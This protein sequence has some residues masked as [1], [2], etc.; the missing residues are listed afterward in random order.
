MARSKND[1]PY[2][3]GTI[4]ITVHPYRKKYDA[5]VKVIDPLTNAPYTYQTLTDTLS[6]R[7]EQYPAMQAMVDA[8]IGV[9]AAKTAATPDGVYNRTIRAATKDAARQAAKKKIVPKLRDL[10]DILFCP[11]RAQSLKAGN[12]TLIQFVDYFGDAVLAGETP[13]ACKAMLASLRQ[14]ILPAIGTTLI[15]ALSDAKGQKKAVNKIN[16]ALRQVDAKD[17][18]RQYAK[19]ACQKLFQVVQSCGFDFAAD[20]KTMCELVDIRKQR[21]ADILAANRADHLDT[22][23]RSRVFDVLS[24]PDRLYDRWII[25]LLYSGLDYSEIAAHTFN[26]FR[27]FDLGHET[28]DY[29][30]VQRKMRKLRDRYSTVSATNKDFGISALRNVVLYPW[31]QQVMT[32]YIQYLTV[33]C[34]YTRSQVETMRLSDHVPGGQIIGN[35]ELRAIAKT[36]LDDAAIQRP[37][38]PRTSNGVT[39]MQDLPVNADLLRQDA[40]YVAR[41]ICGADNV[42]MHAMF[43]QS[44]TETDEESYLDLYGERYTAARYRHL[45]RFDPFGQSQDLAQPQDHGNLQSVGRGRYTVM[46]TNDTDCDQT[47]TLTADYA[48]NAHWTN[49]E[50]E[51]D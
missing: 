26:D 16:K 42:M 34:G 19:K 31:A 15:G 18:K 51:I 48:I 5:I 35:A 17:S 38:L 14:V 8:Q 9:I 12:M 36:V 29:L 43:G 7:G 27:A 24:V 23:Q 41:R 21:N 49:E 22:Q 6:K 20:P 25:S 40:E 1:I 45:R 10:A 37:A 32:D 39:T 30:L 33:D 44:W 3:G 46:L 28:C 4:R 2:M 13:A 11:L 50:R 47:V